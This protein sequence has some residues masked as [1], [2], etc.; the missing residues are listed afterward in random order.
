MNFPSVTTILHGF[1][2]YDNIPPEILERAA[3]RGTEAHNACYRYALK[4]PSFSPV[5]EDARGY[6][7]SFKTWFDEWVVEVVCAEKEFLNT[8]YRYVAHPDLVCRLRH[9]E[10]PVVVDYKTPITRNMTWCLQ[11]AGYLLTVRDD[12]IDA[13]R[14]FVLQLKKDGK[15]AKAV[16]Y[17]EQSRD[18]AAFI[19]AAQ[20]YNY[21]HS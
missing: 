3:A 9:E 19:A 2:G 12:G 11:C 5:Q 21:I 1:G 16:P 4:I 18:I 20:A 14:A 10:K 17:P 7:E 8:T 15:P 6:V 13:A